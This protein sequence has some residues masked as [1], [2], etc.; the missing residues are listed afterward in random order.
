[1]MPLPYQ[2]R[3]CTSMATNALLGPSWSYEGS[4][5]KPRDEKDF[6]SLQTRIQRA[7][8]TLAE[9]DQKIMETHIE[10]KVSVNPSGKFG[11]SYRPHVQ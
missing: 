6:A 7:I 2:V 11:L 3:V 8:A 4:G 10:D 9:F 5:A 1:M